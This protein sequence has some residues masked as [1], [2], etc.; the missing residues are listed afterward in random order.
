MTATN[1]ALTGS[2]IALSFKKPEL[3]IPLAF[4]SHFVL[5][6]IPH[7]GFDESEGV[8]VRNKTPMFKAVVSIDVVLFVILTVTLPLITWFS[9]SNAL[10]WVVFVC[11][12]AAYVPDFVWAY[13]FILEWRTK[14]WKPVGRLTRFH[15]KIQFE[16]EGGLHVE[17][18]WGSIMALAF[19]I[20]I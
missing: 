10:P 7:F 14:K 3:A 2:V 19:G 5:D 1:H 12:F 15:Q 17:F 13:R 16:L 11:M 18:I 8:F 20:L 4:L 6:A 9:N